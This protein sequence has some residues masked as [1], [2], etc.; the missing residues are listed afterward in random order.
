M[1]KVA[2]ALKAVFICLFALSIPGLLILDAFQ[3]RRYADLREQVLDLE[4]TQ[5]DLVEQNKKLITDISILSS[6]ERIEKIAEEELGMKQAE[7][8]QIV[9][10]EMKDKKTK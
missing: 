3:A 4:K 9:R 2:F 7:S 8:E 6:S 1:K 10:V 5:A